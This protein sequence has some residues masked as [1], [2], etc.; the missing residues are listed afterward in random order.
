METDGSRPD[1]RTAAL[2]WFQ[3]TDYKSPNL[4]LSKT[5][6]PVIV[7]QLG[8]CSFDLRELRQKTGGGGDAVCFLLIA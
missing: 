8:C 1:Q 6:T 3:V 4:T 2:F 5:A 7:T